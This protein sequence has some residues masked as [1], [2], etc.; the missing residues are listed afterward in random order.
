MDTP[1]KYQKAVLANLVIHIYRIHYSRVST[2]IGQIILRDLFL[3]MGF[4]EYST[5]PK[6]E[7]TKYESCV[8]VT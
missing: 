2:T 1:T 7:K 4:C 5:T 6:G 3:G 8:R